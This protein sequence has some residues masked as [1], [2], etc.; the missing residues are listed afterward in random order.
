MQNFREQKRRDKKAFLNEQYKE[1][2][3]N[4]R[5]G[6]TRALFKKIGDIKETF[7]ARMGMIKDRNGKEGP[8]RS[9]RD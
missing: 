3:G 2:E 1:I 7:H 6:K 8:N 4:N 5:M 9:R